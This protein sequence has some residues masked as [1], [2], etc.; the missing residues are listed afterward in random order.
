MTHLDDTSL[1]SLADTGSTHPHLESC[2]PCRNRLGQ[3]QALSR[4]LRATPE[5]DPATVHVVL[6]RI[7]RR[8]P[9]R[10]PWLLAAAA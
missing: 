10:T 5:P 6:N 9:A 4:A 8:R 2:E 3:L 7:N 1:A